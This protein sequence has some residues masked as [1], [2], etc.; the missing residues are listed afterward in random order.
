MIQ[1]ENVC[2][3]QIDKPFNFLQFEFLNYGTEQEHLKQ[4]TE[5]DKEKR[6]SEVLELKKQGL[7]NIE[8]AR[9]FGVSEGSIRKWIK[10]ANENEAGN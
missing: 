10:K 1:A 8:I 2:V 9:R 7:T 3:C 4:H 6:T 5:K